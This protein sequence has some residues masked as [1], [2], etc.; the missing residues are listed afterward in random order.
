MEII[1]DFGVCIHG[2]CRTPHDFLPNES[3][4]HCSFQIYVEIAQGNESR[5]AELTNLIPTTVPLIVLETY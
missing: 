5:L 3:R 2:H 4:L 1:E